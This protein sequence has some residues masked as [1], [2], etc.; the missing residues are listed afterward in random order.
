MMAPWNASPS[1]TWAR[2]P[3][4]SSCS[5]TSRGRPG[6]AS[7]TRSGRRCESAPGWSSEATRCGPSASSCALHT[8]AVFSS[9]C[10]ARGI[11]RI[12]AVATSAIRDAANGP[13]LLDRIRDQTGLT[14]RVISGSEEARYGWLAI[15][16]STTIDDGF[17]LDMGGGS[18]QTLRLEGRRLAGSVSL[19]LGSVR[20]SE[21]F[22]PGEKATPKGMRA[23]RKRVAADLR[24]LG[25]WERRR[26]PRRDRRDD[27]QPGGRGDEAAR[28]ARHRRAGL[29]A[30]PRGRRGADRGAGRAARLEARR[31]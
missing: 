31:R 23:L 17:G 14:A 24:E 16:N 18:I 5:G 22:L 21:E 25:W 12:E 15:A 6:G 8:A 1:S 29:R 26:A 28:S 19:P 13:E 9:F 4:A 30:H 10:R 11:D 2:T 7:S 27:P 3:G 20:V